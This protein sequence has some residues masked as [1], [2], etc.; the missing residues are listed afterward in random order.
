MPKLQPRQTTS[1]SPEMSRLLRWFQWA[2]VAE[3]HRLD[4]KQHLVRP[5]PTPVPTPSSPDLCSHHL[6]GVSTCMSPRNNSARTSELT[7]ISPSDTRFFCGTQFSHRPRTPTSSV[8]GRLHVLFTQH[9]SKTPWKPAFSSIIY[10][11]LT[12]YPNN[13]P[14]KT[15]FKVYLLA[16]TLYTLGTLPPTPTPVP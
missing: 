2:A 6:A 12:E 13:N 15:D 4:L 8:H 16:L 5:K 7:S 3:N 1:E 14:I 11:R 9:I 10:Q